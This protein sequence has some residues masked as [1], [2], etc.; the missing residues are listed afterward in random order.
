MISPATTKMPGNTK[1][2]YVLKVLTTNPKFMRAAIMKATAA[3]HKFLVNKK[4]TP[5]YAGKCL[6]L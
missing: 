3:D 1:S 6:G 4:I 2:E 5:A